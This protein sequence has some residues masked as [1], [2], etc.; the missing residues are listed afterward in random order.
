MDLCVCG[1]EKDNDI[2]TVRI[3]GHDVE[4]SGRT[5]LL[6][7]HSIVKEHPD[8]ID[9]LSKARMCIEV[10]KEIPSGSIYQAIT[11][12]M[13]LDLLAT[14]PVIGLLTNL[15]NKWDFIWIEKNQVTKTA[16]LKQPAQAFALIRQILACSQSDGTLNLPYIQESVKRQKLAKMLPTI[17]EAKENEAA[18]IYEMYERY[19][20][21]ALHPVRIITWQVLSRAG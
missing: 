21:I 7:V 17:I 11:E 20:D 14:Q 4:L 2:L 10:E 12:L 3:P 13:A 8:H 6:I 18:A 1:V 15:G 19:R 9:M 5:D 16:S